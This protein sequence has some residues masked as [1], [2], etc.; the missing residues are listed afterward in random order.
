MLVDIAIRISFPLYQTLRDWLFGLKILFRRF[1]AWETLFPLSFFLVSFIKNWYTISYLSK[2]EKEK[3][4]KREREIL[5]ILNLL[6]AYSL[7]RFFS[8][9]LNLLFTNPIEFV[10]L[11]GLL[12]MA[13]SVHEFSHAAVADRLGDPTARLS[14]RVT[15]NPLA[16]LDPL[17][18]IL[19]LIAGFGWG[20]PVMFDPFNLKH[21]QR[22][23]A[24]I[25][26]AG[27]C[28]NLIMAI[29]SS[30]LL[31]F[32]S[33]SPFPFFAFLYEIFSLFL[34][35]NI[36]LG[37]FNLIPVGPLDGFKVVAG[38]LPK[39]YYAD[40]MSLER[41]G[42][43]FLLLLVFPVFGGTAPVFMILSPIV[44]LLVNLLMPGRGGII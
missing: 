37:V 34:Y 7:F 24:L 35:L 39:K 25:A 36:S 8:M 1:L 22:D 16:H 12:V 23:S 32:F 38:L 21:P 4:C 3:G 11:A 13:L 27:P 14:G 19:I 30:L 43:I 41:Y 10:I 9:L 40:W 31:R 42:L 2:R 5:I 18:A 29:L 26:L 44:N 6:F 28:A 20:K 17:G 15:L 33:F